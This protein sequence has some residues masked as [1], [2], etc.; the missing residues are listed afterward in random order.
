MQLQGHW[1]WAFRILPP[2]WMLTTKHQPRK[3]F[4][5]TWTRQWSLRTW[6]C[7]SSSSSFAC[8]SAVLFLGPSWIVLFFADFI[9]GLNPA[10]H[11]LD[12]SSFF[13]KHLTQEVSAWMEK[14]KGFISSYSHLTLS[15]DGWSTRKKD[16]IYTFHTT[17]PKRR[18]FFMDAC[19]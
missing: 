19:F 16:E 4:T 7:V 3:P 8:L 1:A 13:P 14:F 15:F 5:T 9:L 2:Q 18:L 6:G 17:T 11:L 12:R 10:F